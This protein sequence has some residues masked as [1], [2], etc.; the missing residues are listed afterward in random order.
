MID[1]HPT[2]EFPDRPDH[3]DFRLLAEISQEQDT[4]SDTEPIVDLIN[5]LVDEPSLMYLIKSRLGNF[6]VPVERIG[7]QMWSIMAGLYLDAFAKGVEFQKRGGHQPADETGVTP[8]KG[9]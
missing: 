1:A 7:P 3:P 9:E 5:E 6:G 2:P 4:R 8:E